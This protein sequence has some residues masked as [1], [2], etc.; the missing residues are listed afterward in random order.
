MLHLL[1]MAVFV[2]FSLLLIKIAFD[3]V[4]RRRGYGEKSSNPEAQ[5][6]RDEGDEVF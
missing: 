1:V 3:W 4:E 2:A 5:G 6:S